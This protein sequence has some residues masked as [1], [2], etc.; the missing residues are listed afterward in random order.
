ME[1][2]QAM[3]YNC[4]PFNATGHPAVT[5][6]AGF[7][8]GLPVGMMIIGKHHDDVTVLKVAHAVETIQKSSS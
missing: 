5:V 6:N 3:L 4:C 2:V 1:A 8:D 7:T